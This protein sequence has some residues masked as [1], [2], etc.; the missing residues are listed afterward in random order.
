MWGARAGEAGSW[1]SRRAGAR[2]VGARGAGAGRGRGAQRAHGRSGRAA[3][4]ATGAQAG[5]RQGSAVEREGQGW[6]GCLGAAEARGLAR[7]VHS[8]HWACFW[9]GSTRYFS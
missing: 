9:P 5:A 3:A 7:A 2:G 4:G 1:A 6:L 8:V